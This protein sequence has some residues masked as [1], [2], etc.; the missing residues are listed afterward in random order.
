[1]ML[2]AGTRLGPYEIECVLGAGGFGEVYKARDARLGRLVALKVLLPALAEDE[3]FRARF[4]REARVISQLTHPNICTL[5]DVGHEGTTE[6][7]VMEY[8]EGETLDA[9]LKPHAPAPMTDGTRGSDGTPG[10]DGTRGFSRAIPIDE[11]IA[12]GLQIADALACAHG[13][14]IMHRD[15]KPANVFL[16]KNGVKLLDFG[17]AKPSCIAGGPARRDD[18][19][20]AHGR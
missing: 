12:I 13:A 18:A 20:R 16:T 17:L 14:G 4:E 15:L 19:S 8:L 11:T 1:M 9:R 7:L 5:Y 2:S 3:T 6:Y 10:S